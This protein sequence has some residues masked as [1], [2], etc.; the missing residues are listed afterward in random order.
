MSLK[1]HTLGGYQLA[2]SIGHGGMAEVYK[3]YQP[4]L[5]RWVA[6]KV[7]APALMTD[8]QFLA[9]FRREARTLSTLRHPNILT[10]Y[11]YGEEGGLAYLVA[12]Y[13]SGGTLRSRLTGAP[14]AWPAAAA[15][16]VPVCQALAYAHQ[17]GVVHRDLKP[18]N[19]LMP[20]EDW[21]LLADFGLAK[22]A[23]SS[24]RLTQLGASLGTPE[25]MSPEQAAGDETDQRT[26]IYAIGAMLYEL[27]T[28][29]VP[30]T[31]ANALEIILQTMQAQPISP[32]ER[33]P[34]VPEP[35]A[36]IVLRALSKQ[37]EARYATMAELIAALEENRLRFSGAPAEAPGTATTTINT[38][39]VPP[40]APSVDSPRLILENGLELAVPPKVEVL[41][42]RADPRNKQYPD[43]DL[44]PHGGS[45]LGVS[46]NHAR[47]VLRGADWYLEDLRSTNGTF[48]DGER[49]A[50]GAS[51][52]LH[53]GC[54]MRCGQLSMVFRL[55]P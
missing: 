11:D 42:G 7:L 15:L 12:E 26:D 50:P 5:E 27:L 47:L 34:E 38:T 17:Q 9:R 14:F 45:L 55:P 43:I 2:E 18:A 32:R 28:G 8:P 10:I 22:L 41:I 46:R 52:P 19:L 36:E 37:P 30:F 49:L 29:R 13:V 35:V 33:N 39:I 25:Y 3:A 48:V 6:I 44:T 40:S 51:A 4:R 20:R 16:I 21:P 1:G 23:Q 54:Q 24:E 31:G 53:D